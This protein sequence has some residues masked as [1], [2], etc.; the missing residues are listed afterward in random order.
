MTE[1]AAALRIQAV[2]KGFLFRGSV[3]NST[4]A[5]WLEFARNERQKCTHEFSS[6]EL[7]PVRA[8]ASPGGVGAAFL[9]EVGD[10]HSSSSWN[11]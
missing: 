3:V 7:S 10:S 1:H 2:A 8:D 4:I 5:M 11:G 9:E 6:K